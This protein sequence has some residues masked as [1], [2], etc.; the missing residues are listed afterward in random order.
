VVILIDLQIKKILNSPTFSA[1][2]AI[3]GSGKSMA[4]TKSNE[5]YDRQSA[6]FKKTVTYTNVILDGRGELTK[7]VVTLKYKNKEPNG[8]RPAKWELED[9][10]FVQAGKPDARE[11]SGQK[12]SL[13]RSTRPLPSK[14]GEIFTREYFAEFDAAANWIA[15]LSISTITDKANPNQT[16]VVIYLGS[17]LL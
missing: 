13:N 14:A 7:V 12:I 3:A 11:L 5:I 17:H 15:L 4:L 1:L 2:Q 16:P 9:E 8:L 6:A 10:S